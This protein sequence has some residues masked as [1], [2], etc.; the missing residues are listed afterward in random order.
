MY[1]FRAGKQGND[2]KDAKSELSKARVASDTKA[3]KH[4]F[5]R[6]P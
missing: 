6:H 4:T 3:D 1:S 2:R 5:H